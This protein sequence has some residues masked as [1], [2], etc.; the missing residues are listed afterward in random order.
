MTKSRCL[1]QIKVPILHLI[2]QIWRISSFN[3]SIATTQGLKSGYRWSWHQLGRESYIRTKYLYFSLLRR[4]FLL[5]GIR[6]LPEPNKIFEKTIETNTTS[7]DGVRGRVLLYSKTRL[8]LKFSKLGSHCADKELEVDGEKTSV[9]VVT[10]DA[11][12][13]LLVEV[14]PGQVDQRLRDTLKQEFVIN[15]GEVNDRNGFVQAVDPSSNLTL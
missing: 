6:E 13:F 5:V 7:T 2:Q 12:N 9:K 1:W 14:R 11:D 10:R 8:T 3:R 15:N 4:P